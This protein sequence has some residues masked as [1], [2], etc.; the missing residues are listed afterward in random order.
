[1]SEVEGKASMESCDS[2]LSKSESV[3]EFVR[4]LTEHLGPK[5]FAVVDHWDA[6]PSAIG[7]GNP[8]DLRVLVYV[9]VYDV[10]PRFFLSFERAAV[11]EWADHPYT[12]GEERPVDT[13]SEV[14]GLVKKHIA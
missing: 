10:A 11:G 9:K 2:I 13:L 14:L 1:M 6:D 12:P 8:A 5:A 3:H 7:I 4:A